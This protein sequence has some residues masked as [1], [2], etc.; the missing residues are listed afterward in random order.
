M[1]LMSNVVKGM[2]RLEDEMLFYKEYEIHIDDK[3]VIK[4]IISCEVKNFEDNSFYNN[5]RINIDFTFNVVIIYEYEDIETD[6]KSYDIIVEKTRKTYHLN[7]NEY[8]TSLLDMS[9][10][11]LINHLKKV[12]YNLDTFSNQDKYTVLISGLIDSYLVQED[13]V[14][15]NNSSVSN[16]STQFENKSTASIKSS[17]RKVILLNEQK[18]G[19][20]ENEVA[21]SLIQAEMKLCDVMNK[22]TYLYNANRDLKEKLKMRE[23]Q[24]EHSEKIIDSLKK[25]N[26]DLEKKFNLEITELNQKVK[27]QEEMIRKLEKDLYIK[28]MRLKELTDENLKLKEEI[29]ELQDKTMDRQ[30]NTMNKIIKKV[31]F[32]LQNIV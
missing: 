31:K 7:A 4:N 9:G 21:R 30:D 24:I 8:G 27:S 13:I 19:K 17:D 16:S 29:Q 3:K 2:Y 14:T 26:Q 20:W 10:L 11:K 23:K 12:K 6:I 18:Q 1:L 32:G 28:E 25:C 22:V 5:N 15:I